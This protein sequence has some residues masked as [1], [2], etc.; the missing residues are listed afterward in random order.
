MDIRDAKTLA[1]AR[2]LAFQ[3][4]VYISRYGCGQF[5]CKDCVISKLCDHYPTHSQDFAN[6]MILMARSK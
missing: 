4:I 2:N 1:E 6:Q 5:K 3:Q